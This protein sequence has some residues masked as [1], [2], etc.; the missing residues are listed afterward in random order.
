M[1]FY[2]GTPIS[3]QDWQS[4]KFLKARC[5]LVSF[6]GQAHMALVA[7]VARSFIL[8][9]GAFTAW[10]QG[11]QV[12]FEAFIKFV[13]Q[14]FRH[15]GFDHAFIPDIID[16]DEYA[17]DALVAEWPKYLR[18]VPVYHMHENISRLLRLCYHFPIVAIGS[19]GEFKKPG[20]VIWWQ[21]MGEV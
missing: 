4:A 15:P 16:G 20:S 13:H 6:M 8:D 3:G 21:R 5:A 9:N 11:S 2:H 17:N 7:E 10:T 14:W 1:K 12:D 19:S 18:G